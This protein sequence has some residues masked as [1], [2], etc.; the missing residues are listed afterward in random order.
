M[1]S[2][3]IK[4]S[5]LLATALTFVVSLGSLIVGTIAWF[6]SSSF[7]EIS[8]FYLKLGEPGVV[9]IGLRVPGAM[10]HLGEPGSIAYYDYVDDEVLL[11][12]QYYNPFMPFKPVS[13]MYQSLWLDDETDLSDPTL[14]PIFRMPYTNKTN[15]QES[16]VAITNFY[17]FDFSLKSNVRM[18]IFLDSSSYV[19]SNLSKNN[20]AASKNNVS[21][22][23][24]N[25]I[26]KAMRVSFL[27]QEGYKIWEP[28][29][30]EAS[31]TEFG[32]RLDVLNYDR[33]YDYDGVNKKEYMFGEYNGDQY[34]VYDES[35]RINEVSKYSSFVAETAPEAIPLSIPMSKQ[36]GLVIAKEASYTTAALTNSQNPDNYLLRL[37][38]NEPQRLVVS[39]Y[40][41]G[42]DIDANN[43]IIYASF[44]ANIAFGGIYAPL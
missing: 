25:K 13:G 11:N 36:N 21:V 24:L 19:R 5:K 42:W 30:N 7:L 26:E 23:D 15:R 8:K 2:G 20:D 41:E 17:Q 16:D 38:P 3:F 18:D 28:N 14:K 40:I 22:D 4:N 37:Y 33:R 29:T 12:H 32:G 34:L 31:T 9:E 1:P 6:T 27:S 43:D 35:A 39:V 10:P 44:I